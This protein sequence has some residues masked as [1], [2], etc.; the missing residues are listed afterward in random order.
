MF[1]YIIEVS[2]E[3]NEQIKLTHTTKKTVQIWMSTKEIDSE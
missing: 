2:T 3:D 1:S